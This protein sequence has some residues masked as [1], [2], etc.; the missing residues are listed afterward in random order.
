MI[1]IRRVT[2]HNFKQL[3]DVDLAL[4][5]RGRFLVQG[6][7]EAGKSTLFE[8]IFFALFGQ[9]LATESAGGKLD[10]VIRYGAEEAYVA[11]DLCLA[12]GRWMR[13]TRRVRRGRPNVWE[14]DLGAPDGGIEE[15]RSNRTV[16][17]RVESELG[18]DGEALLNTCFVE[19]KKLE[20]LEGM[21]LSGR[22]ESLMKLLNLDRLLEVG[23]RLR[24]RPA[25]RQQLERLR[26][27]ADLA[28]LQA[29]RPSL[30]T[31]FAAARRALEQAAVADGIA[32]LRSDLDG[33]AATLADLAA[34]RVVEADLAARA[35]AA[36]SLAEALT[37]WRHGCTAHERVRDSLAVGSRA[38]D[39]LAAARAARDVEAPATVAR[40]VALRRLRDGT[41][42]LASREAERQVLADAIAARDVE[43]A[44]LATDREALN[45]TR[46]A[47][48]E[49][50]AAG[51]EARDAIQAL[52]HDW[53]AF[54]VRD[55]LVG[56][57]AA[58]AARPTPAEGAVAL[59]AA[60]QAHT[61]AVRRVAVGVIGV[62][63]A[64]GVAAWAGLA[65]APAPWVRI[66]ALM[67]AGAAWWAWWRGFQRMQ[68]AART[69]G[70][71]EGAAALAE[72][73]AEAQARRE[74][75][76][77]ARLQAVNAVRP[78][79]RQRAEAAVAEIDARLGGR[80][81]AAVDAAL[82]AARA[83]Q[84]Q[85]TA[86]A[87]ALGAREAEL[88]DAVG[89]LDGAAMGAERDAWAGRMA[90]IDR[91]LAGW[92][93]RA[94]AAAA[95]LGVGSDI[96]GIDGEIGALRSALA[97]L[98][99]RAARIP[100]LEDE[101]A[102]SEAAAQR[103]REAAR[104]AWEAL[105]SAIA[106]PGWSPELGEADWSAAGEALRATYAAAGGDAVRQ[107]FEQAARDAAALAGVIA[108]ARRAL[109]EAAAV[110]R[111]RL[112]A[113]GAPA[114]VLADIDA[115]LAWD[116]PAAAQAAWAVAA[117]K[118][119]PDPTTAV[120]ALQDEHDRLRARLDV[121][122]HDVER[123]E[124]TLGLTGEVLDAEVAE[125]V[126]Q[127][128]AR[129]LA[130]R[131]RGAMIVEHA[132]RNV[133]KRVLPSTMAHMRRL[134]PGLTRGRYFDA[135]LSDD[136]RIEVYDE[137]AG[138]WKKKNIFSGGTRDQLSLALRLSFALATLPEERGT[139]P[140]FLFLD[141]PLGAFDTERARAL[142]DL[143]TEGEVA[144]S[145]DQIFLISHV[146]V[147]SSLF[148]YHIELVDGRVAASDLPAHA[149]SD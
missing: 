97:Q 104:S 56:W 21:T 24:V 48:V 36:E 75:D 32:R 139:A 3:V 129:T 86:Q 140:S 62:V 127:D 50:R 85:A 68:S 96:A 25:D 80:D 69:V 49:A 146:A 100:A 81:R 126:W 112:Q 4:P 34:A 93:P 103:H 114:E 116:D 45:D 61:A 13:V 59:A 74:A 73:E 111:G 66:A 135:Q 35:A 9:P 92:W 14:L 136:Y 90:G 31:R 130:V 122:R 51:R 72:R 149:A 125:R 60:R 26:A 144:D 8:A 28:A 117:A 1:H 84:A 108:A 142:I 133:V 143:I 106:R 107:R 99:E 41:A 121:V 47:L 118:V 2:A 145:F 128:A 94:T 78:A 54:E 70:R 53:R 82:H 95:A 30:E 16:N 147:E 38:A 63:A 43:L 137:R 138:A 57:I 115:H 29:E 64:S 11:L 20:K 105:P 42:W 33:L 83:R 23:E 6:L 18:F 40:G 98:R 123:L 65:G 39:E 124:R 76:A 5:P 46:R 131:E 55:A 19:Q 12:D 22:Q 113:L 119:A 15:I 17:T 148:D 141:E 7:N 27:R 71:L 58:L 52:E 88:R 134:L 10:D 87:E 132:S 89:R 37:A 109:S 79:D 101:V 110:W 120:D 77:T 44:R 91:V 67:V 102:A